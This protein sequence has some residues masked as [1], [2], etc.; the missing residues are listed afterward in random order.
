MPGREEF[1]YIL[2]RIENELIK[3]GQVLLKFQSQIFEGFFQSNENLVLSSMHLEEIIDQ[4][5]NCINQQVFSSIALHQPLG[6]DLRWLLSYLFISNDLERMGDLMHNVGKI[7]LQ[8]IPESPIKPYIDLPRMNKICFE[9]LSQVLQALQDKNTALAIEA[10]KKDDLLD[11]LHQKI[12]KELL[13]YM[14]GDPKTIPTAEKIISISKQIE[15]TG[16][17]ITN[18]AER[19]CFM[20][21]GTI[22]DLN[23]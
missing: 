15:R 18:I 10:A 1:D 12:W 22:L 23:E 7:A 4:M 17:H 8:L 9:M 20:E 13:S 2:Q 11:Q 6:K 3:M 16:D 21:T 19:I 14:M 5:E